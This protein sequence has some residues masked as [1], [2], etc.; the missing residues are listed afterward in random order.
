MKV[1]TVGYMYFRLIWC[2][3]SRVDLEEGP[4]TSLLLL[5]VILR[6]WWEI[7]QPLM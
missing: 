2:R 3:L 7:L 4:L 6:V 5:L 1:E